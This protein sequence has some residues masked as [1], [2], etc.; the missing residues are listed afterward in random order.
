MTYR[1]PSEIKADEAPVVESN[2]ILGL[3]NSQINNYPAMYVFCKTN[4]SHPS[5]ILVPQT[6]KL[7][8]GEITRNSTFLYEAFTFLET[9]ALFSLQETGLCG[10]MF[11]NVVEMLGSTR[12][13][14]KE[15][16]LLGSTELSNIIYTDN[17][18]VM[19]L[20]NNNKILVAIYVFSMVCTIFYNKN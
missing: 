8:D 2:G 11:N 7:I 10:Y 13:V 5:T 17:T 4:V 6:L 16:L 18:N 12:T 20:L 1:K 9:M 15:D 19:N 3:L 14:E